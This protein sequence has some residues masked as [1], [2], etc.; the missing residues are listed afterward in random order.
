MKHKRY[1]FKWVYFSVLDQYLFL[2]KLSKRPTLHSLR[3]AI[4]KL[5]V[6]L[7]QP[8]PSVALTSRAHQG[9]P[10]VSGKNKRRNPV[11]YAHSFFYFSNLTWPYYAHS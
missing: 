6:T 7:R 9:E 5:R 3:F 10:S 1:A 4:D 2:E 11:L 8:R